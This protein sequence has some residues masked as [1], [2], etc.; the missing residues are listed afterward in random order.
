[1]T[2]AWAEEMWMFRPHFR[3]N[4]FP[5]CWNVSHILSS[6]FHLSSR[7]LT[8]QLTSLY[9]LFFPSWTVLTCSVMWPWRSKT[10]S[11]FRTSSKLSP[12]W[13][14]FCCSVGRGC[15]WRGCAWPRPCG[16]GGCGSSGWPWCWISGHTG[17]IACRPGPRAP[18]LHPDPWSPGSSENKSS[19][20]LSHREGWPL[21]GHSPRQP[22]AETRTPPPAT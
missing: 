16:R 4:V 3:R 7:K 2:S 22:G 11:T 1:M 15:S 8:W 12:F 19:H 21:I 17:D 9:I 6:H 5:Q 10:L 20:W 14:T 13:R 18:L